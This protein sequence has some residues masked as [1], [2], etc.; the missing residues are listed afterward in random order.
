M[1]AVSS[2]LQWA[3]SWTILESTWTQGSSWIV[4]W[5]NY[6]KFAR[7]S[8]ASV[9]NSAS[10]A[11]QGIGYS[12][13]SPRLHYESGR[14]LQRS[15][16]QVSFLSSRQA[17]VRVDTVE[18]GRSAGPEH[19]QVQP[20]ISA[21]IRN[22]LHWLPIRRRIDFKIALM[23]RHCL[24]GAAPEYLM[25]LCHPVGSAVGR[26]CLWS[27]SRGDLIVPRFLLQTFG[28]RAFSV[29][30]PQIWN[31]LPLRIRQSRDNLL[32]FKQKLKAHLFQQFWV[33]LWIHI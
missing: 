2:I 28:H 25:E 24:V 18:L 8:P 21:A 14:S 27:A 10:I 22:E 15:P 6:V 23:V 26:Q 1:E 5:A 17:S 4:R 31:S 29:S 9:A 20:H 30:G 11:H 32:L 19:P 12:D 16:V 13:I 7:L 33:L 3:T